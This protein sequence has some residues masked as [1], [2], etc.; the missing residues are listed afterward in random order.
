MTTQSGNYQ[1]RET[2][3]MTKEAKALFVR[4]W[5]LEHKNTVLNQKAGDN[6][7]LAQILGKP[8]KR[9]ESTIATTQSKVNAANKEIEAHVMS[10]L[11]PVDADVT[12]REKLSEISGYVADCYHAVCE[13]CRINLAVK[14]Y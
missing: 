4:L 14:G 9:F 8:Y 10:G 1:M 11:F 7:D 5:K 6:L 13:D 2:G 12:C 3:E